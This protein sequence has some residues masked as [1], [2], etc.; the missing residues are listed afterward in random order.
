M[1]PYM[2]LFNKKDL[3]WNKIWDLTP[4]SSDSDIKKR[5]E[6]YYSKDNIKAEVDIHG[7]SVVISFQRIEYPTQEEMDLVKKYANEWKFTEVRVLLNWLLREYPLYSDLYRLYGQSYYNEWDDSNAMKWILEAL[8]YDPKDVWALLL[9]WNMYYKKWKLETAYK[10]FKNAY[11]I[12]PEDKYLLTSY[13]WV[14]VELWKYFE[15]RVIA[16]RLDKV[17]PWN[18]AVQQILDR[19]NVAENK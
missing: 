10:I 13:G 4:D 1:N 16:I 2:I 14:C 15:A 12:E 11:E 7:D 6:E 3:D 18:P 8:K 5:F 19:V 9:L 17:D